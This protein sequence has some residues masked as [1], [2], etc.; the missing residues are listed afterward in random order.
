MIYL[1]IIKSSINYNLNLFN[2]FDFINREYNDNL[3]FKKLI[4]NDVFNVKYIVKSRATRY[5]IV[6]FIGVDIAY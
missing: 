3:T 4:N 6:N 1:I 2:I 5:N